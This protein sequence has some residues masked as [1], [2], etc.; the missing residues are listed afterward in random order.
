MKRLTLI[1]AMLILSFA[2]RPEAPAGAGETE[3]EG[4][5]RRSAL[6]AEG[7]SVSFRSGQAAGSFRQ[8]EGEATWIAGT[9]QAFRFEV[10]TATLEPPQAQ[11]ELSA[12]T[13][14]RIALVTTSVVPAPTEAVEGTH[15]VMGALYFG[16]R[17]LASE[18][19][20]WISI[21][22]VGTVRGRMDV[23]LAAWTGEPAGRQATLEIDLRFA[24]P[25]N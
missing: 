4:L 12:L 14:P 16:E 5:T 24:L 3:A 6:I 13:S 15:R 1:G 20:A 21:D 22:G 7:S 10:D 11:A 18:F 2:C 25:S 9:L 23:D 8:I 19:P 17:D